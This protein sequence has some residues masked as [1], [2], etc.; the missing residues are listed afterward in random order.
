MWKNVWKLSNFH[1]FQT[2]FTHVSHE[3]HT[4]ISHACEILQSE[5]Y[6]KRVWNDVKPFTHIFTYT[7]HGV[8]H[9][10]SHVKP[11]WM[12]KEF[13][14]LLTCKFIYT[15]NGVSHGLSHAFNPHWM[16][17]YLQF[18]ML[19]IHTYFHIHFTWGFTWAFT[20]KSPVI[21][22]SNRIPHATSHKLLMFFHTQLFRKSTR[23]IHTQINTFCSDNSGRVT[24]RTGPVRWRS[25]WFKWLLCWCWNVFMWI[26]WRWHWVAWNF[27]KKR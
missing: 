25:R 20:C 2:F 22:N 12:A 6:V 10:L 7:S 3:F 4:D 23:S 18:H 24:C 14:M 27:R 15:S 21:M 9:R 19:L 17:K 5:I 13:H 1:S 26:Q 11:H 8:S 16:A